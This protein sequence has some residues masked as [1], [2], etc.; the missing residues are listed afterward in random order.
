M[1]VLLAGLGVTSV[2]IAWMAPL[3]LILIVGC[4]LTWR[5]V[6]RGPRLKPARR[7]RVSRDF[8][9]FSAAR[10]VA[11]AVEILLEWADVLIVGALVSPRAA[12]I[13]AVA[14]RRVLDRL[15]IE[16]VEVPGAGCCGA[17]RLHLN[18][19]EGARDDARRN[20]DAWWPLL[21]SGAEGLVM[22]A[23]GCGSPPRR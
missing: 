17:V 22:T 10:G 3:P 1:G 5:M 23:S 9:S 13:Y 18:E 20:I 8:W 12:G 4:A 16:M 11:A 19:A 7:T 6:E 14:T 15:G 21:E 2:L